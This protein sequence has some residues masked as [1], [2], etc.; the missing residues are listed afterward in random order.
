MI[1]VIL[2][3][4][5][6]HMGQVLTDILN[7]DPATVITGGIDIAPA[8]NVR[9]YP[10]FSKASDCNV[11][12]D[13][14]IDFSNYRA[15]DALLDFCV[16]RSL[17]LVLCTTAL[18]DETLAKVD[19]CSKRIPILR[20]ANMSVGIN[21]LLK[22]VKEAAKLLAP[23]GYDMEI[24]EAHHNRKIDAPSGTALALGESMNEALDNTYHFVFSR[25][26]RH[27]K[28]DPKEIGISSVRGGSIVGEHTVMFAG[29]DEVIEF[30][31]T[32]YSRAIFGKGA[33]EAAKFLA[34]K[35]AGM[36]D[37]SDVIDA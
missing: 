9:E 24:V 25:S 6:G 22:L 14:V 21:L 23:A 32:A 12:A 3:G 17:P 2:S 8:N 5:N 13:V 4:C 33:V 28:R 35:P 16:E 36:Y 34:G 20:S 18:T 30:K 10:I 27:E 19:A 7:A 15:V 11:E 26:D 1:K 37:M 31:H 29:Q